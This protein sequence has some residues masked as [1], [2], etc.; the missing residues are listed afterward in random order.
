MQNLVHYQQ[1]KQ[2]V[3]PVKQI[4]HLFAILPLCLWT[5]LIFLVIF[6]IHGPDCGPEQF[7]PEHCAQVR[8]DNERFAAVKRLRKY[9]GEDFRRVDGYW[10]EDA[11]NYEENYVAIY[12][13]QL[14]PELE[15]QIR[16]DVKLGPHVR[17]RN[18]DE[19]FFYDIGWDFDGIGWFLHNWG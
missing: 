14:T 3:G 12:I 5:Y 6:Q 11:F 9:F 8:L 4:R 2:E 19:F 13:Y 1:T 16:R 10:P 17:L 7:T 18:T 15:E